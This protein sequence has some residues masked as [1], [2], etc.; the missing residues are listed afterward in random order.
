MELVAF[1]RLS[2][3]AEWKAPL[4]FWVRHRKQF[5]SL[6]I[7]TGS[8]F[9]AVASSSSCERAVL[10]TG[11]LASEERSSLSV[12]S[13]EMPSLV[14]ANMALVPKESSVVQLL[15]RAE[16][17]A[18]CDRMNSFV[19]EEEGGGDG[20]DEWGSGKS[21]GSSHDDLYVEEQVSQCVFTAERCR[22]AARQCLAVRTGEQRAT[23]TSSME[24]TMDASS[25]HTATSLL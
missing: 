5:P 1:L 4:P 7:L 23:R 10:F 12:E 25:T 11:R 24:R 22:T 15:M 2:E 20:V 19:A 17:K 6:Y 16:A 8:V 14:A 3:A 21:T 18:F 9:G 13:V